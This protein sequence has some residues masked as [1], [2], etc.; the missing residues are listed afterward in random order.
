MSKVSYYT[1]E[2]LKKLKDEL[3][4]LK[5]VERPKASQAIADARDKG[6]LSE[7]AEYDAAKEAQGMLEMR[8]SKMEEIVANARIIDESQ[9][10][11]SK[12]LVHSTVKIKNQT[13]GAVMTYKLV[14]QSEADLKSGKI[15]VDSP[16]G[17]GLLGKKE[18][19]VAE[20]SVPNGTMK[21][22][23]LEISRD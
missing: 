17:K 12:V 18:G 14:A 3:N 6:D 19:E 16:I 4:Q 10:D 15:S 20:V 21:F 7:N 2:G 22:D 11:T 8:I 13:N 23:I 1:A 5:D 9:L